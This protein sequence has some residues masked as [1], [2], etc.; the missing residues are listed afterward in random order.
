[1]KEYADAGALKPLDSVLDINTYTG[2]IYGV[3]LGAHYPDVLRWISAMRPYPARKTL[4][5]AAYFFV[6]II[7][8]VYGWHRYYLVYLYMKNRD[9]GPQAG[10]P[11]VVRQPLEAR[12]EEGGPAAAHPL[13]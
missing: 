1:M 12:G 4:T 7:L 5:L 6:L 10:P 8:A 13:P 2:D 9:K 11:L 3:T